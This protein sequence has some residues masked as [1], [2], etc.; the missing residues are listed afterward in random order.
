MLLR[1]CSFLFTD[2]ESFGDFLTEPNVR[3]ILCIPL[4][5]EVST[6]NPRV[7]SEDSTHTGDVLTALVSL[8]QSGITWEKG[9]STEELL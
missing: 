5:G 3:D 7:C 8:C 2:F 6:H 1:D 9:A 4:E